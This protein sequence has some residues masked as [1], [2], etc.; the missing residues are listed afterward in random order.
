MCD[1][2]SCREKIGQTKGTESLI[3]QAYRATK[4]KRITKNSLYLDDEKLSDS[5]RVAVIR[6][7]FHRNIRSKQIERLARL[8][9]PVLDSQSP[10]NLL[11]YGPS[12]AGKS[13]TCIH[14]LS[15]LLS[16]C[17]QNNFQYFFVDLTTPKTCFGALNE[18]AISLDGTIR[19]YR[20]GIAL[21]QIQDIIINILKLT[22]GQFCIV[23]DEVD[24]ITSDGDI[25]YT[26]L[27]K[28]LPKKIDSKLSYIFLTN[29]LDWEKSLDPR[30]FS[31]LKKTDVIFE[32]Y[33][34]LDLIEILNIRVEKALNTQKVNPTAIRK[35]AAYASRETGDARKAV[36]LLAKSVKVAEETSGY[37]TENEVDIAERDLEIDKT[38]ELIRSLATQQQLTLLACYTCFLQGENKINT[39]QAYDVYRQISERRDVRA[40]TQRRFSDMIG[41][42]DLYGLINVR[43]ISKGRYGKTREISGA[44]P[45]MVIELFMKKDLK[46]GNK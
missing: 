34:A 44:L 6:E 43:V 2:I 12:G 1:Y 3:E 23:V 14:F 20:K 10:P 13:V 29:R 30:I 46:L 16:M 4:Q 28:T 26:F 35:I 32:P 40:L 19:R 24:N 5:E 18:L 37:L 27:S 15:T 22:K 21:E 7:I 36:E 41:F 45:K 42:L 39:G 17:R 31:V 11:I 33:D 9:S 8:L 38:T 25:F